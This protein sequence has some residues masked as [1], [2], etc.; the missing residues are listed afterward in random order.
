MVN[1]SGDLVIRVVE[2]NG[3]ALFNNTVGFKL[4]YPMMASVQYCVPSPLLV[5][6]EEWM[7]ASLFSCKQTKP[8]LSFLPLPDT[9]RLAPAANSP[10]FRL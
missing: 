1:H 2:L 6:S 3:F 4:F 8:L 10:P 5:C 9:L 7:T